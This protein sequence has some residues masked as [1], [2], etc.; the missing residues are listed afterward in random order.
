MGIR[1]SPPRL[2][3][4]GPVPRRPLPAARSSPEPAAQTIAGKGSHAA[5]STTEPFGSSWR[6]VWSVSQPSRAFL[7]QLPLLSRNG[8]SL[9][10]SHF[11]VASQEHVYRLLKGN[12]TCQILIKVFL[13]ATN[14]KDKPPIIFKEQQIK[15][16]DFYLG[17]PVQLFHRR[18]RHGCRA[19]DE[20]DSLVTF[21]SISR[22]QLCSSQTRKHSAGRGPHRCTTNVFTCAPL[23]D[24][25]TPQSDIWTPVAPLSFNLPT[26]ESRP[27]RNPRGVHLEQA[28]SGLVFWPWM[29]RFTPTNELNL[30]CLIPHIQALPCCL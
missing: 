28:G 27:L 23:Q 16:A 10:T 2:Q 17:A 14:G 5:Q 12:S 8:S 11:W 4:P 24:C 21:C 26:S 20:K 15:E 1:R 22:S 19:A 30:C 13:I 25:V 9:I 3:W 18:F 6:F 7:P 29:C